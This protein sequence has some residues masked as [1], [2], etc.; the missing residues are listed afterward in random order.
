MLSPEIE[1]GNIE[2]KRYLINLS[3]KRFEELLSQMKWRLSEGNGIAFY[4]I[5]VNDDGTI[6]N[7]NSSQIKESINNLKKI[8]SKIDSKIISV[9]KIKLN[10]TKYFKIKIQ[11]S[12]NKIKK[13]IRIILLGDTNVGKTTFLAYLINNKLSTNSRLFI[14]NHKHEIESGKTSSFNYQYIDFNDCK[15]VFLDTPGSKDYNKTLNRIFLGINIDLIIYFKNKKEWD[16]KNLY[17]NYAQINNI[18]WIEFNLYSNN[19]KLPNINMK[20]PPKQKDIMKF[21]ENNITKKNVSLNNDS[22]HFIILNFYPHPDL[23]WILSG[24]LK[25]GI[26]KVGQKL[27]WYNKECKDVIVQSIHSNNNPV[28]QIK[29]PVITTICLNKLDKIIIKPKYGFLSNKL[30]SSTNIITIKWIYLINK[31]S[32]NLNCYVNNNNIVLQKIGVNN[33]N[34]FESTIYLI[35]KCDC[36]FN[37]RNNFILCF[38]GI[39]QVL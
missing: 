17:Y 15:Y 34:N 29:S 11:K 9:Q 22:V 1:E 35:L 27:H 31:L 5:G 25:N 37:I 24:F 8:S 3:E 10:E 2:Y 38:N 23:G 30:F 18:N 13:E 26:L 28:N 33:V 6:E 19:N 20:S 14:L 36:F 12:T 7:I 16:M 4:Y 32:D 21:I 39:G